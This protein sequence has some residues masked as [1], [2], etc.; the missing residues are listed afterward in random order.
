MF[1]SRL[2]DIEEIRELEESLGDHASEPVPDNSDLGA[3]PE[4][5]IYCLLSVGICECD[6]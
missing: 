5:C 3:D 4:L 6:S 2:S 1:N